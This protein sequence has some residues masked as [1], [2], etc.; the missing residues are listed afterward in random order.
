MGRLTTITKLAAEAGCDLR[1]A[2]KA[3]KLGADA[4]RGRTGER[5]AAAAERIGIALGA[6]L[7]VAS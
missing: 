4:V 7:V 5:I 1:T 2:E 3:I 6:Q